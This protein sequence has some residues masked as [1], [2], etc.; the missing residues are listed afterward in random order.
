MAS[1]L[2]G[3]DLSARIKKVMT[4]KNPQMSVAFLGPNWVKE[5]FGKSAPEDLKIICDLTMNVTPQAALELANAPNNA[6]L[7]HVRGIEM[8]GKVY[9][10]DLGAVVGSANAT[11]SALSS[12]KRI[13]DGVWLAPTGKAYAQLKSEISKRFKSASQVTQADVDAAPLTMPGIGHKQDFLDGQTLV[14]ALKRDPNIFKGIRFVFSNVPVKPKIREI[15]EQETDAECEGN[16]SSKRD[17][18]ANWKCNEEAWPA[19]FFSIH[20]GKNLGFYITKNRHF[21]FVANAGG[22]EVFVSHILGW[23]AAGASFG[24]T[25]QLASAVACKK[26]LQALIGNK[27]SFKKFAGKILSGP[28]FLEAL[29]N[30]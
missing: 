13:E 22:K 30:P 2:T 28:E 17:Y 15:A 6:N 24:D 1:F 7:R 5:I 18:F 16:D 27:K 8:H 4:G 25:P 26:E 11:H 12:D 20:L 9:L 3:K 14:E 29:S 19:L 10:S 21:H 23:R